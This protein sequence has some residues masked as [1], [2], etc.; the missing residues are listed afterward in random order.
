MQRRW[1]NANTV[2]STGKQGHRTERGGLQR[3]ATG[4]PHTKTNRAVRGR[5]VSNGCSQRMWVRYPI[6]IKWHFDISLPPPPSL[7]SPA[8]CC[9]LLCRTLS[10][11]SVGVNKCSQS[12]SFKCCLFTFNFGQHKYLHTQRRRERKREKDRKECTAECVC[13]NFISYFNLE[14]SLQSCHQLQHAK[15]CYKKA[16]QRNCLRRSKVGNE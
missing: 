11:A 16:I 2:Q 7:L 14:T 15:V 6:S 9:L 1:Q 3:T 5:R 12:A 4:W 13:G 8:L 10:L